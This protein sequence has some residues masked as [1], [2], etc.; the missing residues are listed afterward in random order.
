MSKSTNRWWGIP[1]S[2]PGSLTKELRF[3]LMQHFNEITDMGYIEKNVS[4]H[5]LEQYWSC[6]TSSSAPYHVKQT[7]L[8]DLCSQGAIFW[9]G[10]MLPRLFSLRLIKNYARDDCKNTS[11]LSLWAC[12]VFIDLSST[13]NQTFP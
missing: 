12:T 5:I 8:K 2:N 11:S 7:A 1:N 10:K 4:G 13:F 9:G 3:S 6:H